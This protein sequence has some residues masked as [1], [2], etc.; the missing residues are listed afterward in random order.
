M[1]E[2]EKNI[3]SSEAKDYSKG[4]KS[5]GV[6]LSAVVV[7]LIFLL[8]L[9]VEYFRVTIPL[10]VLFLGSF[11]A[12]VGILVLRLEHDHMSGW[13]KQMAFSS[14]LVGTSLLIFMVLINVFG[15]SVNSLFYL[16][17]VAAYAVLM[18]ELVNERYALVASVFM[19]LFGAIYMNGATSDFLMFSAF[20][21]FLI[22]QWTAVYLYQSIKDRASLIK[23]SAVLI[24]VHLGFVILQQVNAIN[25]LWSMNWVVAALLSISSIF[26]S[27]ILIFGVIPIIEASFNTLT[28]TKLLNLSNPNHPLLRKI[29]VEAPG[30]YHHS[31]MVANLSESAS[32]AIGANGLLARVASYYHDVGK[33]FRPKY[34]IENQHNMKNPHDDMSP[35]DSAEIILS[36]PS[37]GA[38][39]LRNY[40]IPKEIIDIA[41]QH[42]GTTL[43]KFFYYKAKETDPS[44]I[45]SSFRYTGPVPQSR[46]A[47]IINICDSV[48]AAVRSKENP[49]NEEIQKIVRSIIHDRLTDGQLD[50]SSLTL[51]DLREIEIDICDMLKGIF[52]ARIEYPEEAT[53]EKVKEAH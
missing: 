16:I 9:I 40:D 33:S 44:V 37:D 1:Y 32:M 5:Y 27:A 45:E 2:V 18:K 22:S 8:A 10:H 51:K 38:K 13:T 6:L 26:I 49:T 7:P 29:L 46:E 41:E 48:E 34:F 24:T 52:H 12:V 20:I 3:T 35:E 53:R 39:I 25:D 14:A 31:V 19:A 4:I 47:A 42:H 43:L 17:P 28:E 36:H 11:L 50:E 21:F 30:T 15:P 23:T